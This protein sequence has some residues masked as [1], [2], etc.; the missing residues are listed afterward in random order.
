MWGG[1]FSKP[2]DDKFAY[3]NNSFVSIGGCTTPTFA[4]ASRTPKRW[5]V[6]TLSRIQNAIR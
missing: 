1:R 2:I 5:R 3:L 4:E 6:Q